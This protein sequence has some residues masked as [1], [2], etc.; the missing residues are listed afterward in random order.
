M[1]ADA[2][3]KC[4]W[5]IVNIQV[6]MSRFVYLS[7]CGCVC[8]CEKIIEKGEQGNYMLYWAQSHLVKHIFGRILHFINAILFKFTIFILNG[9]AHY[10]LKLERNMPIT[11]WDILI[12]TFLLDKVLVLPKQCLSNVNLTFSWL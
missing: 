8:L 1:S 10:Y 3:E 5:K 6:N 11:F 4:K 12:L 9:S 2:V 7:A